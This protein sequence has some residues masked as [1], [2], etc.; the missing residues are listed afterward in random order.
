MEKNN[1]WQGVLLGKITLGKGHSYHFK[2]V[3]LCCCCW[4]MGTYTHCGRTA[5]KWRKNGI[6][7]DPPLIL[8][9]LFSSMVNRHHIL[10]AL[11]KVGNLHVHQNLTS[12]LQTV[13]FFF[14]IL[15]TLENIRNPFQKIGNLLFELIWLIIRESMLWIGCTPTKK[16]SGCNNEGFV[17]PCRKKQPTHPNKIAW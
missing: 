2:L 8:A 9:T 3:R 12:P 17:V 15:P 10:I 14:A 6:R 5:E 11:S 4:S 1:P 7:F 16:I 13:C